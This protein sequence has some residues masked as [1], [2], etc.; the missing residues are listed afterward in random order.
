MK[1]TVLIT[2][3]HQT[4]LS[5]FRLMNL[6]TDVIIANLTDRFGYYMESP[7]LERNESGAYNF[8]IMK[9]FFGNVFR[10]ARCFQKKW[11]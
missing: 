6:Q 9:K 5:K 7:L 3:M 11:S 4:D 2:T 1:I 10:S 8:E